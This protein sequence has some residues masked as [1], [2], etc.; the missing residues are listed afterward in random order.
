M[1]LLNNLLWRTQTQDARRAEA[2]RVSQEIVGQI[3]VNPMCS[4]YE[5]LFAQVRPFINEMIMVQPFGVG[6]NGAALPMR[7]TPELAILQDPNEQMSWADFADLMFATW[8]TEDELNIHVHLSKRGKVYG[9]SII[10]TGS[11]Y[12]IGT[13]PYWQI[14]NGDG[15]I[16][17][18]SSDEVMTLYFSRSPRNP[19]KGVSPATSARVA[20]QLDDLAMQYEKA[21]FENGAVPATLTFITASTREGYE[22]KRHELEQGL[23]GA[24]NR[25]KTVFL[26]RQ[27]NS[28][29][30][31]T[32]DEVEVKTIQAPNNTLAI[33]EIV[34]IINDKLNKSV[35]VSN[36]IMGDDSSA[37]YDN[38]ELS[39]HQFIKRRIFPALTSFWA[40]FQHELDRITGGLNYAIQFELVVPELTARAATKS[41]TAKRNVESL[42]ELLDAGAT[43]QAAIDALELDKNWAKVAS[44]IYATKIAQRAS[45]D[46]KKKLATDDSA[47]CEHHCDCHEHSEDAFTAFTPKEKRAKQ[48]FERL[49]SYARAIAFENPDFDADEV[50]DEIASLLRMEALLGEEEALKA[51]ERL[52]DDE[53]IFAEIQAMLD[54]GLT[55]S[56]DVAK[57]IRQRTNNIVKDFGSQV[58]ELVRATLEN[59]EFLSAEEIKK[60]LMQ[61]LPEGRAATIA[62]NETLYAWRAARLQESKRIA[63][64]YDLKMGVKWIAMHDAST[65]DVCAAMDGQVTMLGDKWAGTV[66]LPMGT[67]LINDKIVGPAPAGADEETRKKYTGTDT[68]GWVQDMWNDDGLIP[69]V[70]VN[71]RCTFSEFVILPDGEVKTNE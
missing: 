27:F 28:E 33:K 46:S 52:I 38:A 47:K 50:A 12:Y 51:L 57:S 62:R 18:I 61:V 67:K 65:C 45:A 43:P 56:D 68:F 71:C 29:L 3:R 64:Q 15:E 23:K 24:R 21:Y 4:D 13:K 63:D 11:K 53:N 54:E 17:T 60:R 44:N 48:I 20:A 30:N 19:F 59:S 70:H 25:N 2:Q 58:R 26:W 22:Q 8:L 16:E 39:D 66:K 14:V 31:A 5:N 55:L 32:M 10:P 36:F 40:Q 42:L 35:G 6:R 9:Y 41:E 37:K 1:G 49:M 69:H 7:K 34:D